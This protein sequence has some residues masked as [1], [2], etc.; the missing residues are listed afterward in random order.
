[1]SRMPLLF[2]ADDEALAYLNGVEVGESKDWHS[3]LQVRDLASRLRRGAN[4]LAIR[5]ENQTAD[6]R[7]NPAGLI[8]T[9]EIVFADGSSEVL[10]SG[11]S[12]K[13]SKSGPEGWNREEFDDRDWPAAMPVAAFGDA[14]WGRVGDVA[15]AIGPQAT[16]IPGVVRILYML[17]PAPVTVRNLGSNQRCA[18]HGFDPV[19]GKTSD[20][21]VIQADAAG[22]WDCDP[23]AGCDHDWVLVVEPR[24]RKEEAGEKSMTLADSEIAWHLDWTSGVVKTGWIENRVSG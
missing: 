11:V 6:V 9:L 23:P 2:S 7:E 18:V 24:R 20:L 12:W 3:G 1:M 10:R 5:A 17:Q 16:G 4:L 19:T 8:A 21:G 15:T 22:N 14:P 13:A